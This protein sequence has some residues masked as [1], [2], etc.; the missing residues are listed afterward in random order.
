MKYIS[1]V[2]YNF[3]STSGVCI[4]YLFRVWFQTL[5]YS[6]AGAGVLETSSLSCGGDLSWSTALVQ[7]ARPQLHQIATVC[8]HHHCHHTLP[9]L[10]SD[11]LSRICIQTLDCGRQWQARWPRLPSIHPSWQDLANAAR[12]PPSLL[13]CTNIN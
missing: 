5:G 6:D 11:A 12:P 10:A 2:K 8:H 7:L 4:L 1:V 9:R 3:I 13:H